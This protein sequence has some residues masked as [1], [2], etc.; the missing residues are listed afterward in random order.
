MLTITQIHYIRKMYFEK[1]LNYAEIERNTGHNYRTIKKYIEMENFNL[2]QSKE[3]SSSKSDI[4]RPYVQK[5]LKSDKEKKKNTDIQ[6][7]ESM[8]D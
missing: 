1:G 6:P 5:I 4:I 8:K 7:K 3:S 2:N